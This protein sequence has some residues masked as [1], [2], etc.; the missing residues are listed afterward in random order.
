MFNFLF[1]GKIGEILAPVTGTTNQLY[2][3]IQHHKNEDVQTLI[4]SYSNPSLSQ[5]A[6][7]GQA[8]IHVACRHNNAFALDLILSR[9]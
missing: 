4:N 8:P 9:G 7:N 5:V 2:L 3:A 1:D 6:D